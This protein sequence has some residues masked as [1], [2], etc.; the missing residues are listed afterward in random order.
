MGEK[1][2]EAGGIPAYSLHCQPWIPKDNNS[3]IL[4]TIYS[5][6]N[7]FTEREKRPQKYETHNILKLFKSMCVYLYI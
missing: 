1:T 6:Q 2:R 3:C 7:T 5:L 4:C